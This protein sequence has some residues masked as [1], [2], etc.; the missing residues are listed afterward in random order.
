[1]ALRG[2]D[3][4][5]MAQTWWPW[6][7]MCCGECDPGAHRLRIWGQLGC[8]CEIETPEAQASWELIWT[9]TKWE[10]FLFLSR[11][12]L[13]FG[14]GMGTASRAVFTELRGP[15]GKGSSR[16]EKRWRAEVGQWWVDTSGRQISAQ[17]QT[18]L[19]DSSLH[20]W[21]R[22][23]ARVFKMPTHRPLG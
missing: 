19:S 9:T 16:I 4:R 15:L 10:D 20:Q 6:L 22:P 11:K 2:L 14:R 21:W 5:E 12:D 17:Y 3:K 8:F 18:V 23:I 13:G 1:M 7:P